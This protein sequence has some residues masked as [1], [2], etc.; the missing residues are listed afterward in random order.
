L[1]LSTVGQ[2]AGHRIGWLTYKGLGMP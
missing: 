2:G 1:L